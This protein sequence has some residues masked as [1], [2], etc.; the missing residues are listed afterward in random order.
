M[1]QVW[2]LRIFQIVEPWRKADPATEIG[3]TRGQEHRDDNH[4]YDELRYF[5]FQQ[6]ER[7]RRRDYDKGKFAALAHQNGGF[8]CYCRR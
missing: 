7:Q 2:P 5:G 1:R 4:Q 8:R 3:E 6:G